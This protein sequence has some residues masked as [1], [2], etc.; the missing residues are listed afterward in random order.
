M[1]ETI[2]TWDGRIIGYLETDY[3]GNITARDFYGRILGKYEKSLD[4][5]RDFYGRI[6]SRGNTASGL[7]WQE[8]NKNGGK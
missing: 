6:V 4:V 5:T 1:K 8:Y 3:Q 7:I 2:R